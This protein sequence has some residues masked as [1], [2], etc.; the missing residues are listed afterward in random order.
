MLSPVALSLQVKLKQF[1]ELMPAD[2]NEA[3]QVAANGGY[4]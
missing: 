2:D 1:L 3:A 4:F